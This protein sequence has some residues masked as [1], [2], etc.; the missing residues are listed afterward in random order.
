MAYK[1]YVNDVKKV[2]NENK[3]EF[4]EKVGVLLVGEI[5]PITPINKEYVASRGNLKKSITHE[6]MPGDKGVIVGVLES[7]K[8]G[9]LVEKGI[10]QPAQPY[11]E[12]GAINAIPKIKNVAKSIYRSKLG[13]R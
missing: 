2:L 6:V 13:G 1:S 10:G 8:Y 7:A 5:V 4:C 3:H 9:I 11:L 12:P